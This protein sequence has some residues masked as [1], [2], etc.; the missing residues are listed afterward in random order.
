MAELVVYASVDGNLGITANTNHA[1]AASGV[2]VYLASETTFHTIGD[3]F[4]SPNYYLYEVFL[5]FDTSALPDDATIDDAVLAIYGKAMTAASAWTQE[6]GAYDY[7]A[8]ITTADWQDTTELS[9]LTTLATRSSTGWSN[10]GYNDFTN[11]GAGLKSIVSKTGLTKIAIWPERIRTGVA[12]ANG[13][14]AEFWSVGEDQSGERRPRL[15]I[16]YTEA[17]AGDTS[18]HGLLLGVG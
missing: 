14:F 8:S 17:S 1:T 16:T 7:G 12:P 4:F 15:T 9:A 10:A 3:A 13:Q 2:G 6:T 5:G 11:T 18:R